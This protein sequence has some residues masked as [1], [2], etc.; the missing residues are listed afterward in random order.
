MI[1][2]KVWIDFGLAFSELEDELKRKN[3]SLPGLM[4]ESEDGDQFLVG[5][6]N[7]LGGT[8][9]DCR[10]ISFETIIKRYCVIWQGPTPL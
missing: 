2:E 10:A 7:E 6:I 8:C 4:I 3:L 1:S 5:H 9:D